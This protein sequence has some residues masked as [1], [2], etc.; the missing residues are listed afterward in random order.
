MF[1]AAFLAASLLPA[2]SEVLLTALIASKKYSLLLLLFFATAGN[3]AGACLNWW[4][5]K[6]I[7]KFQNKKWFPFKPQQLSKAQNTFNKYGRVSLLFSWLPI[8]GDPL[9]FAAGVLNVPFPGF[10]ILVTIGKA[11]RYVILAVVTVKYI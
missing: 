10:L 3:V 5:G 1:A 11:A 8:V 6:Y 7:V 2:Q 9:T 4:L